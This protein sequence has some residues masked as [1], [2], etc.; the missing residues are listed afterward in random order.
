MTFAGT[1]SW[2]YPASRAVVSFVPA[3]VITFTGAHSFGYLAVVFGVWALVDA[4]IVQLLFG[5]AFEK[6]S[7]FRGQRLV[8]AIFG[9]VAG[10]LTLALIGAPAAARIVSACWAIAAGA[11]QLP[12]PGSPGRSATSSKFESLVLALATI[13]LG[14]ALFI[15]SD[16]VS[17]VGF[18]GAY[19]VVV[20]GLCTVTALAEVI[21]TRQQAVSTNTTETHSA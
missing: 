11:L 21:A 19:L 8:L 16:S 15:A 12:I 3:L 2:M 10:A 18:L 5:V 14:V 9:A 13:A 1:Q 20:A 7:A 4:L 6:T 17:D